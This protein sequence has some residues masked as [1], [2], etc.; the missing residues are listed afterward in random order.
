MLIEIGCVAFD[1]DERS[2][3]SKWAQY[4]ALHSIS[5]FKRLNWNK[6]IISVSQLSIISILKMGM[7]RGWKGKGTKN[8]FEKLASINIAAIN[9]HYRHDENSFFSSF[10]T[11]F[12]I[13]SGFEG[14]FLLLQ[15]FN[16]ETEKFFLKHISSNI[17][18]KYLFKIHL[19]EK[20]ILIEFSIICCQTVHRFG[21]QSAI[22]VN[23]QG[24]NALGARF[25]VWKLKFM[26]VVGWIFPGDELYKQEKTHAINVMSE[27]HLFAIKR[28]FPTF[29]V[30][31]ITSHDN[32]PTKNIYWQSYFE[33]P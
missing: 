25:R 11:L 22:C 6:T 5:E 30:L 2:R 32:L 18:F 26:V 10:F 17:S 13:Q 12:D 14:I 19:A 29:S 27:H 23:T 24:V 16:H 21:R 8:W 31:K 15:N 28:H 4:K 7:S 3:S 9:N 1:D 33:K 20:K